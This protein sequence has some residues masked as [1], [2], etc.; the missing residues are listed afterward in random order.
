LSDWAKFGKSVANKL[1]HGS[2]SKKKKEERTL[3]NPVLSQSKP[4]GRR[5]FPPSFW[6]NF[7][8]PV[9]KTQVIIC[10]TAK[11][12]DNSGHLSFGDRF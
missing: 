12:F 7:K 1:V 10:R 6:Y 2:I 4:D 9:S 3:I 5:G 8:C 11:D